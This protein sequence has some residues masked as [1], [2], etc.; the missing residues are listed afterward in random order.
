[1]LNCCI[2]YYQISGKNYMRNLFLHNI[3]YYLRYKEA[4]MVYQSN[5]VAM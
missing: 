3:Y 5:G 2:V 1:M 4:V